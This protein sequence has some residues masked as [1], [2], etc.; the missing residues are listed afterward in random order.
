MSLNHAVSPG[1]LTSKVSVFSCAGRL[2]EILSDAM[3]R[4]LPR[5]CARKVLDTCAPKPERILTPRLTRGF[6]RVIHACIFALATWRSTNRSDEC[7]RMGH[8][9]NSQD[10]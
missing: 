3:V 9:H 6:K 8:H 1:V 5:F 7:P 10:L 4:K 2:P